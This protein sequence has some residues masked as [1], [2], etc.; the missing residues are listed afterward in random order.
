MSRDSCWRR[1][2]VRKFR[3]WALQNFPIQT[4]VRMYV[5]RA[6]SMGTYL[7]CYIPPEKRGKHATICVRDTLSRD[8]L[9]DTLIEEWAHARTYALAG[10]SEEDPHHHPTFWAEYGRIQVAARDATW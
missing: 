5:R 6:E 2:V 10:G 4:P 9:L 3:R 7:G 8:Q 1:T